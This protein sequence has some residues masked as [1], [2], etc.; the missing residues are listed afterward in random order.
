MIEND[1][2]KLLKLD[3]LGYKTLEEQQHICGNTCYEKLGVL[4]SELL[5][6]E[7]FVNGTEDENAVARLNAGAFK[8]ACQQADSDEY[9]GNLLQKIIVTKL[10]INT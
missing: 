5:E 3:I 1:C 7:C 10:T 6:L 4:F 9:C 8:F 2:K